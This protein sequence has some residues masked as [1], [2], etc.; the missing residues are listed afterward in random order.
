MFY[1]DAHCDSVNPASNPPHLDT[2]RMRVTGS[3]IQFMACFSPDFEAVSRMFD[4][5]DGC[6]LPN[7]LNGADVTP[8]GW[9]ILRAVEGGDCLFGGSKGEDVRRLEYLHR[10][11]MR[12]LGL[13]WNNENPLSGGASTPEKGLTA[14][15]AEF[16]ERMEDMGIA[17]DLAHISE[18]GFWDAMET[19]KKP[20]IVS[21]TAAYAL[22]SH[23]RNLTDDQIRA[24]AERGGVIGVCLYPEFLGGS[25]IGT[26]LRHINH[27]RNTGG[28]GCAGIGT[29]FDGIESLPDGISSVEDMPRILEML[30][31]KTAGLNFARVLREVLI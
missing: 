20:P 9:K 16:I 18:R 13:T 3:G 30:D 7:V 23:R 11:G 10:R 24:V 6:G 4:K 25:D 14:L 19:V 2:E 22:R 26:F 1:I 29:D 12:S 15:G 21:H 31:E 28:S 17:V 27:I 5:L 8:D